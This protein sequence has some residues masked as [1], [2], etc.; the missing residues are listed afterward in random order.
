VESLEGRALL[1]V[2]PTVATFG[3]TAVGSS[4]ATL[5]A[6]VTNTGG[7]AITQERFSWGS[8]PSCS[9]GWTSAVTVNGNGFSYALTGLVPNHTY[10][11]QAWADNSA[12]WGNGSAVAFT[13]ASVQAAPLVQT[14][15]ASSVT[16]NSVVMNGTVNPNGATTSA[17][18]QYGT[19]TSYGSTGQSVSGIATTQNVQ[20]ALTGLAPNTTYHYRIVASNGSGT[21]YGSDTSFT[22]SAATVTVPNAPS[23]LSGTAASPAQVK[24]TWVDNSNNEAGFQVYRWNGTTWAQIGTV[25]SNVTT[26]TDSGRS[27][28][29]TYYYQVAAFNSAGTAWAAYYATVT[30][31]AAAVTVPN[32]P[33]NLA[34]TAAS[35][36]QVNLSWVDNSNNEAGFK[37]DRWNSSTSAWVQIGTVGS[38]VTTYTDTGLSPSTTYYYDVAAY[39]SAGTAWAASYATVTT[40]SNSVS[41]PTTTYSFNNSTLLSELAVIQGSYESFIRQAAAKYS[42]PV[43]L[44]AA[45]GARESGWG[46][47][48]TPPGPAGTGDFTPRS[49]TL[50]PD[51][52]G[53][54]RGLMQIDYESYAFAR[55]GNWKDPLS[56]IMEGALILSG[57]IATIKAAR[58][59]LSGM[60]LLQA[61]TA[62]YNAGTR[63]VLSVI[64]GTDIS[65]IDTVTTGKN[66]SADVF[67][68]AGWFQEHGLF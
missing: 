45:I 68:L 41:F 47:L 11:C 61:A 37:I 12:G 24:L 20:T 40:L 25:G 30:T 46:S 53:W 64:N 21:S 1:S 22:T 7:A 54:G 29:T 35:A 43:A 51:G 31:P 23:N 36:T 16:A 42:V 3:A 67:S 15:A 17:Y 56:N 65:K 14:T 39:N 63:N 13:T 18:F 6:Q 27:P 33:S 10:Y 26:Y 2:V 28:S 58:P 19:T 66:Y 57:D 5:S 44:L 34:G 8:T 52:G 62:A 59:G 32:A 55:T 48:L 38:N 60:A 49:G 9:D 4:S 50:P